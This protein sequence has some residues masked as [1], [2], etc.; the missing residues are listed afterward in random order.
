MQNILLEPVKNAITNGFDD[1]GFFRLN[2]EHWEQAAKIGIDYAVLEKA[3]DIVAIPF[4]DHWSD[5]GEWKAVWEE[6]GPDD[7]G[8]AV[9]ENAHSIDCY[10]TLLSQKMVVRSWWGLD[11]TI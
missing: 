6:V 11:L 2:S 4:K 3:N 10:N 9:S 5:V 7:N 8:V 1:L